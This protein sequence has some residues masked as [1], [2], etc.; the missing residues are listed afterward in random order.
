M[1]TKRYLLAASL[2]LLAGQA[3]AGN[4]FCDGQGGSGSGG[5]GESEGEATGPIYHGGGCEISLT[6]GSAGAGAT[7]PGATAAPGRLRDL[8]F[9]E[10][11]R[12]LLTQAG[13][14]EIGFGISSVQL[15]SDEPED[16]ESVLA[17]WTFTPNSQSGAPRMLSLSLRREGQLLVLVADWKRPPSVNWSAAT[18]SIV[19]PVLLDSRSIKLG[20]FSSWDLPTP[21]VRQVGASVYLGARHEGQT[22]AE[23]RFD[24]PSSAW[25]LMHLRN[26]FLQGTGLKPGMRVHL[27]WPVE[28]LSSTA[29]GPSP[30]TGPITPPIGLPPQPPSSVE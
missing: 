26:G 19:Q 18:A 3:W 17:E 16:T 12:G 4:D 28:F 15:G 7:A 14:M 24:L 29:T 2:L 5:S 27:S 23:F 9:D 13:V 21:Y 11:L 20:E 30:P 10:N 6:Y 1:K 8:W 22:L 25:S